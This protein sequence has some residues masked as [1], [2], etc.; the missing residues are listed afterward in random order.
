M[1]IY[2]GNNISTAPVKPVQSTCNTDGQS[3]NPYVP[4]RK[5]GK[6]STFGAMLDTEINE[7]TKEFPSQK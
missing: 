6:D 1:D 2:I 7:I 4:P 5:R 3:Q